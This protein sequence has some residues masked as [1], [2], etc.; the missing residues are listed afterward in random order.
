MG[1]FAKIDEN[2]IVVEVIACDEK[3]AKLL[4]DA[5]KWIQTSRNTIGGV[6]REGKTPLRM[7]Y[8]TIGSTYDPVRNAFILP[9]P[10]PSFVLDESTCLWVPPLPRPPERE[11]YFTYWDFEKEMWIEELIP[12]EPD[13]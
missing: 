5:D 4:P 13:A 11:G 2:N 10:H 12:P 1:S 8:A 6:H 3:M 7:N 9:K